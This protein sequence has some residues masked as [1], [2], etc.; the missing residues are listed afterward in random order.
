MDTD[1]TKNNFEMIKNS[2]Y[3]L[4]NSIENND[5]IDYI[6]ILIN[7]MDSLNYHCY[8]EKYG[9]EVSPLLMAIHDNNFEV[10]SLLLQND[11]DINY[12][13]IFNFLY[14]KDS[15]N[16][17]NLK[18]LLKNGLNI[19]PKLLSKTVYQWMNDFTISLENYYAIEKMIEL[20]EDHRDELLDQLFKT[21][22]FNDE[23]CHEK[24]KREIFLNVINN[25]NNSTLKPIIKNRFMLYDLISL[26]FVENDVVRLQHYITENGIK[27]KDLNTENFDLL[28]T[29][30]EYNVNKDMIKYM[31]DQCHYENLDY[32]MSNKTNKNNYRI[33]IFSAMAN[34]DF[35][36]GMVLLNECADINYNRNNDDD[37]D[38]DDNDDDIITY[39]YQRKRLTFENLKFIL[40]NGYDINDNDHYKI[41]NTW[42]KQKKEFTEPEDDFTFEMNGLKF[43]LNKKNNK[44]KD[45]KEFYHKNANSFLEIFLRHC[46][47]ENKKSIIKNIHYQMAFHNN[48][49]NAIFILLDNDKRNINDILS[50]LSNFLN[51][52]NEKDIFLNELNSEADFNKL[53]F[54]Y[55]KENTK[56]YI[57]EIKYE[58][59]KKYINN[60]FTTFQD[61]RKKIVEKI[62]EKNLRVDELE[63]F[64]RKNELSFD[65][66][67]S[68]RF[69]ILIYAIEHNI[70]EEIVEYIMIKYK[71]LNYVISNEIDVSCILNPS[72]E[73]NELN[74]TIQNE[75]ELLLNEDNLYELEP[76]NL[77]IQN[78][79]VPLPLNHPDIPNRRNNMEPLNF[80]GRFNHNNNLNPIHL[81]VRPLNHGILNQMDI[82][83]Q[84]NQDIQNAIE[85]VNNNNPNE[86]EPF[87]L[88]NPN[89]IEQLNRDIQ[90]QM[91]IRE[92][93]L[94]RNIHNDPINNNISNE[95]EL[96]NDD[97]RDEEEEEE[98]IQNNDPNERDPLNNNNPNER[99]PINH[100][101]QNRINFFLR[102]FNANNINPIDI[103]LRPLNQIIPNQMNINEPLNHHNIPNNREPEQNNNLNGREPVQNN[104]P[105]DMELIHNNNLNDGEPMN[106]H[107]LNRRNII[108]LIIRPLDRE[109]QIQNEREILHQE[110]INDREP[111][112]PL[113]PL[114]HD[115]PNDNDNRPVNRHHI[116]Q[117]MEIDEPL[118]LHGHGPHPDIPG[119]MDDLL[120]PIDPV[121]ER[122]ELLSLFPPERIK[123]FKPFHPK[124]PLLV[125]I[126][127]HRFHIANRLIEQG[128][129]IN[130]NLN[131]KLHDEITLDY[132]NLRYLLE[133]GYLIQS[134]QDYN[135]ILNMF[136]HDS[137]KSTDNEVIKKNNDTLELYLKSLSYKYTLSPC[138]YRKVI[139]SKN[140]KTLLILYDNDHRDKFIVISI[141][142]NEFRYNDDGK[143]LF[144]LYLK[145]SHRNDHDNIYD[146][147]THQYYKKVKNQLYEN[148]IAF[149]K[150]IGR[151]NEFIAYI[152]EKNYMK[153]DK[154]LF[155]SY[156]ENE[157]YNLKE[158]NSFDFDILIYAIRHRFSKDVITYIMD[159]VNY[160]TLNY[161]I[162]KSNRI[163]TP[164]S[165]AIIQNLFEIADLLVKRGADIN[166]KMVDKVLSIY[167]KYHKFNRLLDRNHQKYLNY[168]QIMYLIENKF[169]PAIKYCINATDKKIR[170][171]VLHAAIKYSLYD[172]NTIRILLL[173]Y[174]RNQIPS[175]MQLCNL[176]SES[177]RKV[178]TDE[179]YLL[180]INK[181]KILNILLEYE[182]DNKRKNRVIKMWNKIR[183]S[184]KKLARRIRKRRFE[185]V[186]P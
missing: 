74:S 44:P 80:L 60:Y 25:S 11:A 43:I 118:P 7:S 100:N 165:E 128:A 28:I 161:Y 117:P 182:I 156:I 178:I 88:D 37:G 158:M 179:I 12:N 73:T 153:N 142:L 107:I 6:K 92:E 67:N 77:N 159:Q 63:Q 155:A 136:L 144:L 108:D 129:D 163:K 119:G 75:L 91:E 47:R 89:E 9:D 22:K 105:N 104:N 173:A 134:Y 14:L 38:G 87:N 109:F 151:R 3:H 81:L 176:L 166:Y 112:E 139:T 13:N 50:S 135:L 170:G 39:L 86:R 94:G 54:Y 113:E 116:P 56:G 66:I 62:N 122:I 120:N 147:T 121:E 171:N 42:I 167:P 83:E 168:G 148:I 24:K 49:I 30:I 150:A 180:A 65:E 152:K 99:E 130:Y 85:P 57:D 31:I 138:I 1:Y 115:N 154:T 97:N 69:D 186:N 4:L 95:E 141:I 33:P 53:D 36:T 29:A 125:S 16:K 102:R 51:K 126:K 71:T 137:L 164:L 35:S 145:N 160:E 106:H 17:E 82:T 20:N 143:R 110:I 140:Y 123:K 19:E 177:V 98:P 5:S 26:L 114:D 149:E 2:K 23:H 72:N 169:T 27:L 48:N 90:N 96:I 127:N 78:E 174:K 183:K 58:K 133:H 61:N 101:I 124:T 70:S 184:N 15:I 8:H 59:L 45:E 40:K 146:R 157:E 131:F 46:H 32:S 84:F 111:L 34:N 55:N 18:F 103:L 10:A 21:L 175:K 185:E 76:L 172:S 181:N 162:K 132:Q 52:T 68:S 79:V 93:P 64:M 41:I